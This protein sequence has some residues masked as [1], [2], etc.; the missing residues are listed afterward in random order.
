MQRKPCGVL[1]VL[2]YYDPLLALAARAADDGFAWPE[3]RDLIVAS[4]DPA[5]LLTRMGSFVFPAVNKW[6]DSR[7]GDR[8]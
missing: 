3:H 6:V 2:G 1:N 4:D 8:R 5:D 7:P